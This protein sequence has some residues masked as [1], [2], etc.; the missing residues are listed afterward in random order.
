MTLHSFDTRESANNIM[1]G[2][3]K[4]LAVGD[5]IGEVNEDVV[6]RLQIRETIKTHLDKEYQLYKQGIKVLSLFF[7]DEVAK[8]KEYGNKHQTYNGRY[9]V[10]FEEEY[11][12]QVRYFLSEY[13]PDAYS[14]YI[15]NSLSSQNV[16]TGY[17]S[18]DK[19]KKSDKTMFVDF[20]STSDRRNNQSND[21]DAY[22]LIMRDKERLLSLEEPVRFIFLHSALKK[23]W[24][25][26][27]IFQICTLKKS[28]AETRKRQEIGRG[29]RLSVNQTGDRQDEELLGS[30]V[31]EINKLTVLQ[32]RAM[33]ALLQVYRLK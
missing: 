16:H 24:D 5:I 13:E 23:G 11:E 8:Y 1:V 7:I 27:N 19:V 29:M 31:H 18:I 25:N 26:P 20:K 12:R 32:T 3:N 21:Q 10:I 33:R 17:F 6:R 15:N 2:A 9:A 4:K 30:D 14:H 28:N 22:D